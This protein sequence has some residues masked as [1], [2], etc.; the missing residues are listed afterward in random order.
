MSR[1]VS[2]GSKAGVITASGVSVG[3]LGHSALTSLGLGAML[4][5]S[6]LLFSVLKIVGAGYFLY[7]GIRLIFNRSPRLDLNNSHRVSSKKLFFTG[8]VSNIS[9]PN[10]TIFYFA[11]LPQF[12]PG[13]ANN[14]SLCLLSLGICFAILTFLVK[15]P[16]GYFA[17][18]I[19][20]IFFPYTK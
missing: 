20:R 9:N 18:T 17:G 10:V 15:G 19:S 12:I 1:A 2:Q 6:A 11:F 4:L 7:L 13:N 5:A 8:A 14:P 16:V 3:L